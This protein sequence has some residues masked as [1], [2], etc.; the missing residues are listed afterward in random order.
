[1]AINK[2]MEALEDAEL[3]R[4]Y[5]TRQ[6]DKAFETL[7]Q[8]H[9]NLVYS[10]ALRQVGAPHLAEE[11]TQAVFIVLSKKAPELKEGTVLSGWL[12]RTARF[13]AADALKA[14]T[15]RRLREQEAVLM[16]N[17]N[18]S[19]ESAWMQ[20]A[21]LLDEAM[22]LL[23]EK[24]RNVLV[25]RFFEQRPLKEV[26]IVL[27]IDPD[28]AQKRISRAVEKLRHVL[29]KRGAAVSAIALIGILS[30]NAVQAA[31]VGLASSAAAVASVKGVAATGSTLALANGA[32]KGMALLKL[33]MAAAFC[34]ALLL[35][36]GGAAVAINE[37]GKSSTEDRVIWF[38]EPKILDREPEIIAIRQT[39]LAPNQGGTWQEEN[40]RILALAEPIRYLY[41]WAY[42]QKLGR[43]IMPTNVPTARYDFMV[44][45]KKNQRQEFQKALENRF[46][47]VGRH[48]QR[49]VQVLALT[50]ARPSNG[51][52][53]TTEGVG[54]SGAFTNRFYLHRAPF[55]TMVFWLED[56]FRM[57]VVDQTG[58]TNLYNVELNWEQSPGAKGLDTNALK[59]ALLEQLGLEL[60]PTTQ[61]VDM[62]VVEKSK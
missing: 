23:G 56:Y 21:P 3:L 20:I 1:V 9:V 2:Q 57:P 32:M 60:K 49:E 42:D 5:V 53:E 41:A 4:E 61:A 62:V 27:G 48:E 17:L 34:I 54:N 25:L 40:D 7:V 18:E 30:A 31:P 24:D 29:I 11:V 26:G 39:A 47:L 45:L 10:A 15:R 35:V 55:S 44:G 38:L 36:G 50:V 33:K 37:I 46:G 12:Y 43:L 22:A 52:V 16:E 8:R 58:L 59:Q 6:S 14:E 13:V 19:T 28:T 51:I